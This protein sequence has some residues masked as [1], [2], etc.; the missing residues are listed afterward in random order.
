V[1]AKLFHCRGKMPPYSPAPALLVLSQASL[2]KQEFE[3]I[4]LSGI[5]PQIP[6][7]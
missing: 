4:A 6:K 5:S 3:E 7:N 2:E 1:G